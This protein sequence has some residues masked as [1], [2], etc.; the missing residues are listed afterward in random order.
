MN[1]EEFIKSINYDR[2]HGARELLLKIANFLKESLLEKDSI[3]RI[4]NAIPQSMG[5]NVF[6][7]RIINNLSIKEAA[8]FIV[9][10]IKEADFEILSKS[11]ALFK[12]GKKRPLTFSRSS[13]VKDILF[14]NKD[15]ID[16]IIISES[17][18][19]KEARLLSEELY[20]NGQKSIIVEDS[21]L[22]LFIKEIDFVLLG[23]DAFNSDYFI[24]KRGTLS[25]V[26]TARYLLKKVYTFSASYKFASLLYESSMFEKI[27]LRYVD[28]VKDSLNFF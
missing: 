20:Y 7:K 16:F 28:F 14:K 6:L 19:G 2:I 5:I 13:T 17:L 26:L 22:S 9:N 23:A 15:S 12:E 11:Q 18:P 3:E 21:L 10:Y 27:P 25:L 4:I 8:D 24:N 1:V